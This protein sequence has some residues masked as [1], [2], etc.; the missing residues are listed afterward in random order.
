MLYAQISLRAP[1]NVPSSSKML[2]ISSLPGLKTWALSLLSLPSLH[3]PPVRFHIYFKNSLLI[4][5]T[6]KYLGPQ[7]VSLLMT[8]YSGIS[9]RPQHNCYHSLGQ[10]SGQ[11]EICPM[12]LESAFKGSLCYPN[13][14]TLRAW[15]SHPRKSYQ[16]VASCALFELHAVCTPS[17]EIHAV[18]GATSKCR[19]SLSM[20]PVRAYIRELSTLVKVS[21]TNHRNCSHCC[22]SASSSAILPSSVW[23]S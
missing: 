17:F 20:S 3:S 4:F 7:Y 12:S 10:R 8:W 5:K 15:F 11:R 23:T 18:S 6:L 22:L 1:S 2:Q 13:S 16:R 21:V 9:S 19:R 14:S